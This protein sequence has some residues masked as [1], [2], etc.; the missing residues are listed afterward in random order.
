MLDHWI[1]RPWRSQPLL[2]QLAK[3]GIAT[4]SLVGLMQRTGQGEEATR[5][6]ASRL[7]KRG[8]LSR[9]LP[10]LWR[11]KRVPQAPE[12]IAHAIR[13][14]A[15]KHEHWLAYGTAMAA[16]GFG[17]PLPHP[18]L[19]VSAAGE[20]RARKLPDGTAIRFLVCA[21]G[22]PI[23]LEDRPVPGIGTV[24]VP[25]PESVVIE[26]L[27]SLRHA[28]GIRE[29]AK[30]MG[31][32][33]GKLDPDR[34]VA[35]ALELGTPAVI[36]RVGVLLELAGASRKTVEPLREK[37]TASFSLLDPTQ[38]AEGLHLD[39]WRVRLNVPTEELLAILQPGVAPAAR[40]VVRLRAPA[41]PPEGS[42]PP[43]ET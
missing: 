38:P 33:K 42:A 31:F 25:I 35:D 7:C 16:Y 13:W 36:R 20:L 1:T 43:A 21:D 22:L 34:I 28:G 11:V 3:D 39:Y 29:V 37:L 18:E 12:L 40:P 17:P 10:G 24:P 4:V 5:Q 9:V 30:F 2:S 32:M 26:C 8:E 41:S 19:K 6:L 14:A 15:G 23:Q 27:R